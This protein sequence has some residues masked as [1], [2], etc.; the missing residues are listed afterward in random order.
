MDETIVKSYCSLLRHELLPALGCT[1]PIA[2]AYC[3]AKARETL[4]CV[5]DSLEVRC[6]GNIIKNVKGV[7]V[8]NSGGMKGVSAA[9]V[10]GIFGG[11][12]DRKLEVLAGVTDQ[13]REQTRDYLKTGKCVVTLQADEENL[14]IKC[15]L[16]SGADTAAVELRSAHDHISRI[17]KNGQILFQQEDLPQQVSDSKELL[18]LHDI[19]EFAD[20][21]DLALIREPLERQAKLNYSIA[22]EG[23]SHTWGMN[24]GEAFCRYGGDS[25]R[26]K[27]AAMAAAGS[28]ARMS[29]CP[30]PVVIN[31]GSGNQGITIAIPIIVYAQEKE[32]PHDT[33]L[34]GLALANL[35]AIHQKRFIGS[36]S[37]YCGAVSAAAAAACG[38]A[39]MDGQPADVIS[40]TIINAISTVGGILCDGAKPSCAA[41]IRSS[42]DT[43]LLAYDLAREGRVYQY[44][45]GLVGEDAEETIRNIGKVGR[46]GMRS[47]D[48][49]VLQIMIANETVK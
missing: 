43:A 2:I 24:V 21:V 46:D 41:K 35:V 8:P 19:Y 39:Y 9:A 33:M 1:E 25:T 29:G 42:V 30:L 15:I 22:K 20:T 13:A 47:T 4:G 40:R 37:A 44:G 12:A 7:T 34:R 48:Q 5:P 6:S 38:I 14:Y 27:A 11:S 16:R 28:D 31:S 23:M 45:D 36:L 17:E 32:I 26:I 18:N 10:L 49:E 3:A